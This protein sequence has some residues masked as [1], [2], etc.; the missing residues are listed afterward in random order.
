L[1]GGKATLDE[2]MMDARQPTEA[3]IK[4]QFY[5]KSRQ[6]LKTSSQESQKPNRVSKRIDKAAKKL[7]ILKCVFVMKEEQKSIARHYQVS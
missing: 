3:E 2:E 7:E 5:I 1:R 6:N 4:F